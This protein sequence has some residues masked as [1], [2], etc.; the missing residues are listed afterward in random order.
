MPLENAGL[1]VAT[2]VAVADLRPG[3]TV[4]DLG[5]GAGGDVLAAARRVGPAGRV[6]GLDM[7]EQMLALS[8]GRPPNRVCRTSSSCAAPSRHPAA[9]WLGG[10]VISNC[11]ITLSADK[12]GCSPRSPGCLKPGG[13]SDQ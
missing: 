8:A 9:G 6:I 7:T 11:V 1:G 5:S 10:V 13:G 3:E 4:L 2:R 12:A